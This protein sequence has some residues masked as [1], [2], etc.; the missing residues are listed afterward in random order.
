MH[1]LPQRLAVEVRLPRLRLLALLPP[2]LR[3]V[4]RLL[5]PQRRAVEV[6]LLPVLLLLLCC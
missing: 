5:L 3:A 4:W 6:R 2:A 1:L